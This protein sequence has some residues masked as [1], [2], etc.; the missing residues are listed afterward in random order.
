MKRMT[1]TGAVNCSTMVFAA[2]VSL[3]ATAN[4]V[5]TPI[6]DSAP[7]RTLRL[8]TILW[9][10]RRRKTP[11]TPAPIRLRAPLM[12]RGDQGTSLMNSPPVEKHTEARNTHSVYFHSMGVRLFSA[13]APLPVF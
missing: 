2:V 11:I 8:K 6:M 5:V 4:S 7:V 3:L 1:N 10:V 12:A 9:R 13:I